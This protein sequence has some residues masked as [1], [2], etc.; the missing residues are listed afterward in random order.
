MDTAAATATAR[1]RNDVRLRSVRL[2]VE[3]IPEVASDWAMLP[4]S[5]RVSWSQAWDNEMGA[6]ENL[7]VAHRRGELTAAQQRELRDLARRIG[8]LS[9]LI[10]SMGLWLPDL[11]A[12]ATLAGRRTVQPRSL[13]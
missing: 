2:N 7:V 11:S 1:D 10:A 12:L 13:P 9:G 8:E 6:V 5:E 4:D 3:A